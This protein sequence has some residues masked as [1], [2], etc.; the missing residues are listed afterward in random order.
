MKETA[1]ETLS[2]QY[3]NEKKPSAFEKAKQSEI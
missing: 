1:Q 2:P 3:K